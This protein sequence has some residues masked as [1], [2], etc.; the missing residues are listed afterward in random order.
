MKRSYAALTLFA[1]ALSACGKSDNIF[2]DG[3][4][5]AQNPAT[6]PSPEA[7]EATVDTNIYLLELTGIQLDYAGDSRQ[8]MHGT[9]GEVV[10][11]V[12]MPTEDGKISFSNLVKFSM[13]VS[14]RAE[15]PEKV[16]SPEK[17]ARKVTLSAEA[18]KQG[19]VYFGVVEYDIGTDY[20]FHGTRMDFPSVN[21]L[22]FNEEG[23]AEFCLV[24]PLHDANTGNNATLSFRIHRKAA[25][26]VNQDEVVR[27]VK[28]ERWE[29]G[30]K[31]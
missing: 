12:A 24:S 19:Y 5:P 8:S 28:Y 3:K 17:L 4:I 30:P 10:P 16:F 25:G 31:W 14:D 22:S 29:R 15:N 9:V 13:D 21:T 2:W 6:T 18:L 1:L 27:E 26:F 11:Q 20:I 23:I 7:Q